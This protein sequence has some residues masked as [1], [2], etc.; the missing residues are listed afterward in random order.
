M[1]VSVQ[2][3]TRILIC[4]LA[5][6][7]VGILER[8]RTLYS[9]LPLTWADALLCTALIS[10]Q[11]PW[12]QGC[13]STDCDQIH[14]PLFLIIRGEEPGWSSVSG[15]LG[16]LCFTFQFSKPFFFLLFPTLP[17]GNSI[18]WITGYCLTHLVA[19]SQGLCQDTLGFP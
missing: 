2:E 18:I 10:G 14:P 3:H 8:S 15:N 5:V 19:Q 9:L 7:V 17:D 4:S 16:Q 6:L 1:G 13:H 12:S 11:I